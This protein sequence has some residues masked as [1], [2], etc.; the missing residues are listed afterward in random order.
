MKPS[1]FLAFIAAATAAACLAQG[2]QAAS[3]RIDIYVVDAAFDLGQAKGSRRARVQPCTWL[4]EGKE[5]AGVSCEKRLGKQWEQVW[6]E[7]VPEGDGEVDIDLQGEW[8]RQEGPDDIRLV[9]AD[10]VSVEG[11]EIANPD[12]EQ[13]TPEG[14]PVGWR[15]TGAF[16]L[17][18]YSR[19]AGVAHSGTSCVA[20]W[21]GAQARQKFAVERGSK[22]RVSAWFRVLDPGSVRE[23]ARVRWEFPPDMYT[24]ELEITLATEEAA[25]RASLEIL[26][27]YDGYEWAISS[28]WDDN[29]TKGDLELHAVLTKH[30]HRGTWYLNETGPNLTADVANRLLEGGNSLGGHSLSH[31]FLA[32]VSRNRIFEEVAG[33][34]ADREASSDTTIVSYA[35]SFCNFRNSVE[36]DDVHADITRALE[37]AGYYNIANG[38]YHDA[39]Q[40]DMILS[41]IMPSD[42]KDIDAF[43]ESALADGW[44]QEQH[45][46][47]SY[48][49]HAWYRTPE[50]WAKFERHLD[51]YGHNPDW[52]YCNQNEYA[53]Y[54]YQYLRTTLEPPVRDGNKLRVR[55]QRPVLLD[56]NDRTPLTFE[57]RGVPPNSVAAIDCPT[58]DC[59]P[60]QR[61]GA[62]LRFSLCHDRDRGL[63]KKI[64]LIHNRDNHE[65]LATNDVD[66]DYPD[67]P[68]LLHFAEGALRLVME[69]RSDTPLADVRVTYRLPLA[70]KE[71]VARHLLGGVAV[72]ARREDTLRPTRATDGHKHNSGRSF[73]LAQIDF[74]RG[75]ERGRLYA[76]CHVDNR[77]SDR[78]YP[79]GGFARLGPIPEAQFDADAVAAAVRSGRLMREGWTLADGKRLDWIS[80]DDPF[81]PPYLDVEVIRTTGGW[82]APREVPGVHL[83]WSSLRSDVRQTVELRCVRGSVRHAFLNGIDALGRP[84]Q[85]EPG[86]GDLII[87][88]CPQNPRFAPEHAGCFL[89]LVKPGTAERLTNVRFEPPIHAARRVE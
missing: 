7:F 65:A 30:G 78:S 71:G 6:V 82:H 48:S 52:W 29:N 5:R 84:A 44:F 8:Y 50:A 68:A 1:V 74:E 54:R 87:A 49:M 43:A 22:Y 38:W 25:Q 58:A 35:F 63:P 36:G 24:Q 72:G 20:V 70:W 85:L 80:D 88:H 77:E 66:T 10:T 12:F 57:V 69:N 64:G 37:R 86:A 81:A 61:D 16:P 53:A 28:R 34:R 33:I 27:L 47:L 89:R 75:G 26:P 79:Q 11:A 59:A 2:R 32:Y 42:G 14:T 9:W 55:L 46:N 13:A 21:Y 60:S 17:D 67:L 51:R 76:A 73:F 62:A 39:L 56:V 23:P 19:D 31:P 18:R 40:T 45:P 4:G 41:P 3:G 15:F 83:L